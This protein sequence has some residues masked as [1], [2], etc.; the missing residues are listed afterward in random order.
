[1]AEIKV[2]TLRIKREYWE[3]IR[4][5]NK[6]EEF[7]LVTKYWATRLIGKKFDEIHLINGYPSKTEAEAKTLK[8]PWRGF[9]QGQ[10]THPHFGPCPVEVF[11]IQ[12]N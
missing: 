11:K 1:M 9:S 8:R 2:L 12:V 10:I 3:E 4:D 7:R 5:G 6:E